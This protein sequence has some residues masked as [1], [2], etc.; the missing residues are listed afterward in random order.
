MV[1]GLALFSKNEPLLR[2][3]LLFFCSL[4]FFFFF[5]TW[6]EMIV[7]KLKLEKNTQP[8]FYFCA[9][10]AVMSEYMRMALTLELYCVLAVVFMGEDLGSQDLSC[11][12]L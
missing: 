1:V 7:N 5:S 4:C 6:W 8:F 10:D 3:L 2:F 11:S 12:H 9:S